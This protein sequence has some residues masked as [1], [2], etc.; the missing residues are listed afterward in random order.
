MCPA[1]EKAIFWLKRHTI[2]KQINVDKRLEFSCGELHR[3]LITGIKN[4]VFCRKKES[5]FKELTT[6]LVFCRFGVP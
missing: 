3:D 4:T 5:G 2:H 1:E 6:D